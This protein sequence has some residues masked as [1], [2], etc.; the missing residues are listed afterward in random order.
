[1]MAAVMGI[2][3]MDIRNYA[4]MKDGFNMTPN[5]DTAHIG[6]AVVRVFSITCSSVSAHSAQCRA[7]QR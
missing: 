7:A 2:T 6:I 5:T 3:V 4:L 1:M